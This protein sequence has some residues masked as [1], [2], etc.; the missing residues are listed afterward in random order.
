[1]ATLQKAIEIPTEA[2]KNQ[3]DKITIIAFFD[4]FDGEGSMRSF[5]PIASVCKKTMNCLLAM[6]FI[7]KWMLNSYQH[8]VNLLGLG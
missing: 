4:A 1:M 8:D 6:T 3:T 7:E 5:H 2:H